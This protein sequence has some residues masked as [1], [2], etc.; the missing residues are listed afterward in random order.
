MHVGLY[1]A[2]HPYKVAI[3]IY[4][5]KMLLSLAPLYLHAHRDIASVIEC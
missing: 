1:T 3:Q 2:F 5:F 4:P